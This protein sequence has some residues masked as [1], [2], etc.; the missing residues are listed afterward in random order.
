MNGDFGEHEVGAFTVA[1]AVYTFGVNHIREPGGIA[2]AC[3]S[4]RRVED[5]K[6]LALCSGSEHPESPQGSTCKSCCGRTE[7]EG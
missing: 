3:N 4:V 7:D 2:E 5:T 1:G 6:S